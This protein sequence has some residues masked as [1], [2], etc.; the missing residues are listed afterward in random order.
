MTISD[1][2]VEAAARAMAHLFDY[3]TE[4][5][6]SHWRDKAKRTLEAAAPHLM[7]QAWDEGN[8][9]GIFDLPS[10]DHATPNPYRDVGTGTNGL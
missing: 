4:A 5:G 10:E 3:Q 6:K 8:I 9:A 2:A 1:E 7:V